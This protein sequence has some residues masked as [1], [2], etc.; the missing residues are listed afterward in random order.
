MPLILIQ[1]KINM[2]EFS[3]KYLLLIYLFFFIYPS[4]LLSQQS[5]S[6][7]NIINGISVSSNLKGLQNDLPFWLHSNKNG[8]IDK[9]SANITNYITLSGNLYN[10]NNLSIDLETKLLNRLANTSSNHFEVGYIKLQLH[11]YEI[12]AGR[13][14]DPLTVKENHLSIGSFMYSNNTLPIPK[15]AIKTKEYISIPNTNDIVRYS[16][17]FAHGWFN[18]NRYIQNVYLHEKYFYLNIKY[19]FF[20]AKAGIV[21]NVQWGGYRNTFKLPSDLRTYFEVILAK[22]SSSRNAPPGEDTNVVGNSIGAYDFNLG[23]IFNKFDL[24]VYRIFYLE[25]KVSARFRSPW[26]GMWGV[27]LKPKS[28]SLFKNIIY[29]HINTKKMDSFDWE[30]RGTANYYN[31]AIYVTGW[32]Y[33]NRVIGNPLILG[34]GSLISPIYNNIVIGHHF[35]FDGEFI[36]NINFQ[37]LYTFSRN[38]G[39]VEDQIVSYLSTDNCPPVELIVCA[40]LKPL[41]QLLKNNHS[42][43]SSINIQSKDKRVNYG[44]KFS[45]DIGNLYGNIAGISISLEYKLISNKY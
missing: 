33:N 14:Y 15:I 42:F 28:S 29:E 38:Y 45:T 37:F 4:V 40:E 16:G 25:D 34:N 44:V 23:L 5:I 27:V 35:G 6:D 7:I 17:L 36:N 12:I 11:D 24:S 20:D 22:G 18:S 3:Y 10:K 43:L 26:D 8:S 21:H 32:T 41:S 19:A 13:F 31:H 2:R 39:R 1:R 30:P 9:N